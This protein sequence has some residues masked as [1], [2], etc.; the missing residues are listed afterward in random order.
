MKG[1]P[2][3]GKEKSVYDMTGVD[4]VRMVTKHLTKKGKL[5]GSKKEKKII[6]EMCPHHTYTRKGKLRPWMDPDGKKQL[7]CPICGE[8]FKAGYY[9]EHEVRSRANGLKEVASQAKMLSVATGADK[10]TVQTVAE[11]N[12]RL[13]AFP[14]IYNNLVSISKKKD[15]QKRRK[16]DRKRNR[17]LG[18]WETR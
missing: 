1:E 16:K 4:P 15:K 11:F 17:D 5:T 7:R 2:K 8:K 6:R 13:G 3:M 14:K 18:T 10:K 9:E 12:V